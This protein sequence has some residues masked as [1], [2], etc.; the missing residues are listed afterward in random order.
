MVQFTNFIQVMFMLSA[1]Y[2]PHNEYCIAVSGSADNIFKFFMSHLSR[3]FT[4]VHVMDRPPISWGSFE[5]INSTWACVELLSWSKTNWRY[6]QQ[7][8]GTDVPL[9]TNLEMVEIFKKWNNTVNAEF[10]TYQ[11]EFGAEAGKYMRKVL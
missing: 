10:A 5:I 6:Y 3:C 7:L 1:F 8:A 2:R 9:K 4:N 11:Q